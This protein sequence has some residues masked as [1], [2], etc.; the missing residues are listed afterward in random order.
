MTA[1]TGAPT[2]ERGERVMADVLFVVFCVLF[3]LVV[4]AKFFGVGG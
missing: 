2:P 4:V 1:A 3:V